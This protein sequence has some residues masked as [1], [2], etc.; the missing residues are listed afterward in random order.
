MPKALIVGA[1]IGGL[2]AAIALRQSAI[3]VE[4]FEQADSIQEVGA[5][6]SLWANAIEALDAIGVGG[7]I[8]AASV[9]Y[10]VGGLRTADGSVLTQVSTDELVRVF[11]TPVVVLHRADLVASLL[12]TLPPGTLSLGSRCLSVRQ[13]DRS[14]T[15]QMADGRTAS[16]DLL[17]GADG[18][19]S[20]V[21]AALHGQHP[22]AYA[23]CTAWRAVV[24]FDTT[25]IRASESWGGGNLFGQVPISG[26]RVYWY[27][28]KRAPAGERPPAAKAELLRLFGNWHEPIGALIDAAHESAILQNDIFDRAPLRAWGKGRITLLGDAA[29]PMTPFLGQG[30]C[31]ALEDAVVLGR[32]LRCA[33]DLPAALR[34]Y[35]AERIPR[36]NAFVRRS[37]LV[38]RI[39]RMRN[40]LAVAL[41]NALFARLDPQ[42]QARQLAR[43]IKPVT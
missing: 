33:S 12:R 39:A 37:R 43:L 24:P 9:E 4:V 32:R 38:G 18:L 3:D 35:E 8:R 11:G 19:N 16:G 30:G 42:R 7:A 1:G 31:Q 10:T 13:D 14:V 23:G 27:A 26:N 20:V 29:H 36:A 6:I 21:R 28:A 41:R 34:A 25:T 2:A 5:G 15:V 17:I 40:P 22:P